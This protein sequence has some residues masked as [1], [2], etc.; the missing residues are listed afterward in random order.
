M[1]NKRFDVLASE[2]VISKTKEA[3]E[4]NGFKV[5]VAESGHEAKQAALD[6]IPE[7]SDVFTVTSETVANIGLS[8]EINESGKYTSVRKELINL[9]HENKKEQKKVGSTP[10]YAVGSA[11]AVTEDGKIIV[12]SRSGSQLASYAYGADNVIL[13]VSTKKITKDLNEGFERINKYTLPLESIRVQKAYGMDGSSVSKLLILNNDLDNR[14]TV[15]FV[16]EDLGY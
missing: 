14:V 10:D 11:H 12:A 13:I 3:L 9:G 16:K 7:Q 2:D 1:S 4:K 15:I 6:L 5:L 8:E